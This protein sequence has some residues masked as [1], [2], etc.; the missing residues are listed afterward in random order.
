VFQQRPFVWPLEIIIYSCPLD[1][2][3]GTLPE[4][5]IQPW[6]KHEDV[7]RGVGQSI[8]MEPKRGEFMGIALRSVDNA[9]AAP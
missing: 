5:G 1:L 8:I 2:P 4:E 3:T 6:L 9:G 7:V